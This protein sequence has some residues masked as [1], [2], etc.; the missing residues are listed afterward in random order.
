MNHPIIYHAHLSA[1][2]D[3]PNSPHVI[4]VHC[5]AEFIKEPSDTYHATTFLERYEYSAHVLVSPKGELFRCRQDDEIAYHARDYNTNTLGIEFL[6]EG[7]HTYGTFLERIKTPWV[8]ASAYEAGLWQIRQWMMDYSITSNRILR[9][10]DVSPGRKVDPGEGFPWQ[11]LLDAVE[12]SS[13]VG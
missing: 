12:D 10:S 3:T 6:V 9:H 11:T 13:K 4:V 2:G 1:G 8:S 5:M 7:E